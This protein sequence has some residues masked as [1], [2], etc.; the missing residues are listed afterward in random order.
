MLREEW[1]NLNGLWDYAIWP[2]DDAH[3]G[4]FDGKILVPF[5]V[6]SALSGVMKRV[7]PDKRL[8]YRRTVSVPEV[9]RGKR[10]LLHFEAV[11]WEATVSIDGHPIGTHRGGYAP[12]TFDVTDALPPGTNH[13]LAVAVW[14]SVG[15]R[16]PAVR[17]AAQQAGGNLVHAQH[18]HLAD[19]VAGIRLADLRSRGAFGARRRGKPGDD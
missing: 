19:R 13:D 18:G 11:D 15:R 17:Q 16:H 4:Q 12:F 5:P 3:A 2:R 7:G 6:E 10:V 14:E 8:W 9:W 1:Q